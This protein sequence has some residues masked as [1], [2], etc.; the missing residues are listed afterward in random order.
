MI[1]SAIPSAPVRTAWRMAATISETL[2][3]AEPVHW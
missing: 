1:E 3:R 2:L